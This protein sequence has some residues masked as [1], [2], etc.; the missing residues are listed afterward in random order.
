M[1]DGRP[2]VCWTGA[3]G[4]E[5]DGVDPDSGAAGTN[6]KFQVQYADSAGDAPATSKLLIRRDGKIWRQKPMSAAAGGD[7]RLGK[8]YRISVTLTEPA[9][10]EYRFY[11]VDAS[12][13]ALG[14]PSNWTSGPTIT[15]TAS[16]AVTS[17][18]AVPTPTGAQLTFS[19][20]SAANVTA[21]VL[22]VAGRPVKTLVADRPMAAGGQ[23]LLWDRSSNTGLTVPSGLYLVRV[24]ARTDAG[25]QSTSLATVTVR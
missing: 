22:N 6:F 21:T 4:F 5:T 14:P 9:A 11:F 10:Y 2:W 23:T 13:T 25:A 12:G 7:L 17:L 1:I 19:L 24:T 3:T 8:V 20:L 16:P 18:A 15:G